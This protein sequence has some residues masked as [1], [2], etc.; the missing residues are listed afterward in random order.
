VART[1]FGDAATSAALADDESSGEPTGRMSEWAGR[2]SV[3]ASMTEIGHRLEELGAGSLA[4]VGFDS[5]GYGHWF[6]AVN[7][8]GTVLA[9]DGQTGMFGTWP[10]TAPGLGFDESDMRRSDAIFFTPGGKVVRDDH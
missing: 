6:N 3:P 9:V 7:H 8:D 4:I 5:P 1:W 2:K 10:P